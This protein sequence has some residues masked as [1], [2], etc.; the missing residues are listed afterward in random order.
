[1][2]T[3]RLDTVLPLVEAL[4]LAAF[5]LMLIGLRSYSF[6]CLDL[7]VLTF[8]FDFCLYF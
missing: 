6:F 2:E 7:E 8:E 3:V 1:L 4:D 5:E